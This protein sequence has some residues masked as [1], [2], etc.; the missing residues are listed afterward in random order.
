MSPVLK[1]PVV[2][3]ERYELWLI[4][5]R[6]LLPAA[7]SEY[8]VEVNPRTANPVLEL[9][10]TPYPALPSQIPVTPSAPLAPVTIK[11]DVPVEMILVVDVPVLVWPWMIGDPSTAAA[12][13]VRPASSSPAP[14]ATAAAPRRNPRR[15]ETSSPLLA[16]SFSGCA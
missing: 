1:K 15:F 9:P 8:P 5:I 12:C 2:G 14:A 11:L 13:S 7:N 3:A 10:E 16:V 6:G 4:P